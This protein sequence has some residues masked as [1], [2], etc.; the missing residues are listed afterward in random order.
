VANIPFVVPFGRDGAADRAAWTFVDSLPSPSSNRASRR[1][2]GPSSRA[3]QHGEGPSPRAPQRGDGPGPNLLIEN[4][5]GSGGLLGV[6]RANVLA[7]AGSPVLLLA[8]P[9]THI[10]LPAR[11]GATAVVDPAFEPVVELLSGPNVLLVSPR[12]GVKS[13]AELVRRA[14]TERL[15][16]ASAGTGQTIHVCAALFCA[17][18]GI[19]MTHRP[20]AEGSAAPHEDLV[21]GS[22]HMYFDNLLGCIDRIGRGEAVPLAISAAT[23][24]ELLPE[25]PTMIECGFPD[26]VLDVWL[27][28]FGAHLDA[29]T[30]GRLGASPDE[31]ARLS[32]DIEKS[33][34]PWERALE[35]LR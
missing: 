21:S 8:T 19:A 2:N 1:D 15:V 12:L 6:Q 31:A 16:Y 25:V 22:V 3:P 5:P 34:G 30:L 24:H 29:E 33:R 20:Y 18:A 7:R 13:V 32:T 23:R 35:S 9:S 27:A 28:V 11:I 4:H 17:Q 10:L 26:H 14:R